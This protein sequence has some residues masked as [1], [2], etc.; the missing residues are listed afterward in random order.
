[1]EWMDG[2][3]SALGSIRLPMSLFTISQAWESDTRQ[4]ENLK[5]TE[6]LSSRIPRTFERK[7]K[8]A[9]QHWYREIQP[10]TV[11]RNTHEME[12]RAFIN[13]GKK[14]ENC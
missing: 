12:K 2:F 5:R 6:I 9:L 13:N 7:K 3:A 4:R 1:M 14:R 10:T 11:T 8:G